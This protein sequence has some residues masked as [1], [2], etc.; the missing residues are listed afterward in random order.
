MADRKKIIVNGWAIEARVPD[1]QFLA[2]RTG[3]FPALYY[4]RRRARE[5]LPALKS[6]DIL[7]RRAR[8][9]RVRVTLDVIGR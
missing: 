4:T 5:R 2:G 8:V 1:Q 3:S 6:T 7:P 9:I